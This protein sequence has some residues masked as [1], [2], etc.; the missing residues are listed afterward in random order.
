MKKISKLAGLA[1]AYMAAAFLQPAFA[2]PAADV[3]A[4]PAAASALAQRALVNG[5]AAAGQRLVAAGQRGHIL[6]SD[7]HGASWTQARVPVASDL[8][9]V[10][11]PTPEQGWAVGHD[12]VVL[13]SADAG[14][15]WTLQLDGRQAAQAM[16][17][18]YQRSGDARLLEEA[19]RMVEQGPDKPFLDVWFRDASNGYVA[20]A[21]GL[22]FAT[23]DA[24]KTWQPLM[25][26]A[27]NPRGLHLNAIRGI[28]GALYI[29][30]EQGLVLRMGAGEERF[31]A[32]PTPYQGSYF[33]IVGTPQAVIA[34]GLRGNAF[35]STDNGKSWHKVETRV[36]AGLTAGAVLAG[37]R[38]VLASQGGH[39][40]A[41]TDHGATFAPLQATPGHSAALLADGQGGLVIGGVRG[42]RRQPVKQ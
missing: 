39:L 36:P 3:L 23:T 2:G 21:F 24:G 11:F 37:E 40:L 4:T 18:Y 26:A 27:D 10:H 28:G 25:H 8:T 17:A 13:H 15:S 41:S 38:I 29:A 9:A 35:R 7:D 1:L 16:Q 12:G 20:G 14:A 19:R 22:L 30:G 32:V 33:G 34:F 5:L 31:A 6:Y 42:L